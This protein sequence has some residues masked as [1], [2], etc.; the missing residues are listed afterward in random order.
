MLC[1]RAATSSPPS[2]GVTGSGTLPYDSLPQ[3]GRAGVGAI[4]RSLSPQR[5]IAAGAQ[6]AHRAAPTRPRN[7]ECGSLT[8]ALHTA[9]LDFL[10]GAGSS[11]SLTSALPLTLPHIRVIRR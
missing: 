5:E 7:M 1:P 10:H 9:M 8:A 2:T 11:V 3:R 4:V 6:A